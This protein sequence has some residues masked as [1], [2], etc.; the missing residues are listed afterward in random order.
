MKR[1]EGMLLG[2]ER[3]MRE[4]LRRERDAEIETVI[5]R[6]EQDTATTKEECEKAAESRVR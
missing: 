6:L 1:Q 5:Q 2:R 4:E 3:E